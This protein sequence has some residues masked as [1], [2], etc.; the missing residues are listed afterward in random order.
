[1]RSSTVIAL[2]TAWA[3]LSG[4]A[5]LAASPPSITYTT[6]TV[7]RKDP[8][9]PHQAAA[10]DCPHISFQYPVIERAP[11]PAAAA[12]LNQAIMGFLLTST[13]EPRKSKN[14]DEAMT[15]FMQGYQEY[16]RF[17]GATGGYFEERTVTVRYQS[18]R[19]VSLQFS[20][21]FF[22]GGLHPQYASTFAS[23]DA[24]TGAKIR[25]ADVLVPGFGPRLTRI[26]ENKFRDSH[27]IKP[28]MTLRDAGYGFFKNDTFALSNNFWIGPTGITF[29]YNPYEIA[30]YAMG[31]TELLLTYRE[32]GGLI[33]ADGLLGPMRQ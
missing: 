12:A 14:I 15:A 23:F 16:K 29:Y 31:P 24:T 30:G 33:K 25:L 13:G 21:D 6:K 28:G 8:T 26:G 20:V 19:L 5:A 3:V 22:Y 27:G 10:F 9:C 18:D 2:A 17:P 7:E 4:T 32:I 1:M 11:R